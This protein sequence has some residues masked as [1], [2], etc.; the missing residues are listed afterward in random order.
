MEPARGTESGALAGRTVV[1]AALTQHDAP[2]GGPAAWAWLPFAAVDSMELLKSPA[3]AGRIHVI[4]DGGAAMMNGELQNLH[5]MRV[6]RAGAGFR[7]PA[8]S[9]AGMD[10]GCKKQL[11]R[12]DIADAAEE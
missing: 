10:A 3:R 1:R 8:G 2:Y 12:V 9:R 6:H 5:E 4:G 11:V 7:D